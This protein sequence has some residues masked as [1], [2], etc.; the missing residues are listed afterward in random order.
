MMATQDLVL[1]ADETSNRSLG[2]D[3]SSPRF[4]LGCS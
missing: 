2:T 3:D 4:G 1:G